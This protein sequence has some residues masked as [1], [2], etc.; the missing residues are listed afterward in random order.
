MTNAAA[1]ATTSPQVS[2]AGLLGDYALTGVG[3]LINGQT[4]AGP[5][6]HLL[7][8]LKPHP[9]TAGVEAA[10]TT[11]PGFSSTAGLTVYAV[12]MR[13]VAG[14]VPPPP[15]HKRWPPIVTFPAQP[16]RIVP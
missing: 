1:P 3:A 8:V 11:E 13:L 15:P 10:T 12:G 9:E 16:P 7:S 5:G 14:N 2:V 6:G 4:A